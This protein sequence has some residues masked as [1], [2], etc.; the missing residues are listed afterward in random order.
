MKR[1]FQCLL[2]VVLVGVLA[3]AP[4]AISQA[5]VLSPGGQES[6]R[7]SLANVG[8]SPGTITQ[9]IR[10]LEAGEV[11]ESMKPDSKP[12]SVF[13]VPA[14]NGM[15]RTHSVF[16]DG[17]VAVSEVSRGYRASAAATGM[18]PTFTASEL[19]CAS[20]SGTRY[21]FRA[22]GCK[23]NYNSGLFGMSYRFD[24]S[25]GNGGPFRITAYD[26][27]TW[28]VLPG[29][30]WSNKRISG[31]GS[32]SVKVWGDLN[33]KYGSSTMCSNIRQLG[34]TSIDIKNPCG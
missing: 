12:V 32:A 5:D 11:W 3:L 25:S 18:S 9:L 33:W 26:Q 8:V 15:I 19:G 10:K 16:S 20:V 29:G 7:A 34:A 30:S 28:A 4:P 21:D 6:I 23:V 1:V 17:S 27:S 14:N 22:Q 13:S 24:Y 2:G 31:Q